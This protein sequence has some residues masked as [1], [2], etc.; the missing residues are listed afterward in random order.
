MKSTFEKF[1]LKNKVALVTGASRDLGFDACC[2]LAEAQATVAITSRSKQKAKDAAEKLTDTYGIDA[3]GLELDHTNWN[4]VQRVKQ[5]MLDWKGRIDILI[6]NAGGGALLGETNLFK[7]E[8]KAITSLIESNLIGPLFMCKAIGEI[9]IKQKS[10]KIINIASIAGLVGRNRDMYHRNDK[11]EQA[12][13]YA[14]AKGGVIAMTRDLAAL[15]APYGVCVN[16]VS[17]GGFDKGELPASFVA[18]YSAATMLGRMGKLDSDL[19]GIILFLAS[20]ASDYVTA[21]NIIVD[22]GFTFSK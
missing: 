6:N 19:K 13:D 12:I 16:A 10:G 22:G 17:P 2:A 4:D 18:D 21:Q 9:M 3:I 5:D 20:S 7:R 8:P 14:A 15:L 1:Q 11:N